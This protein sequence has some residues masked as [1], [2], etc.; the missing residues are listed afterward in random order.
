MIRLLAVMLLLSNPVKAQEFSGLARVDNV[1]TQ[2]VDIQSGL[3]IDL[4]LSQAVPYRVF[5]LDDPR[6]L[7]LDFREVDWTGLSRA[8]LGGA[9]AVTDLRFGAFRPGWSRMVIDLAAPM[10]VETAGMAHVQVILAETDAETYA[11]NAGAPAD[12]GW[13]NLQPTLPAPPED[14]GPLVVVIDPGHGGIDPGAQRDGVSE[15]DLMLRLSIEVA[16]ALNRAGGV[17]AIL[18]READIFVPL[19]ARMSI[20]RAAGASGMNAAIC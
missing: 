3:Q 14:D 17:R 6:R 4:H 20:A 19:D 7:V 15:A 12:E 2:V 9:T 10:M 11:A 16:E 1:L 8:Q 5:T 13:G 18:T